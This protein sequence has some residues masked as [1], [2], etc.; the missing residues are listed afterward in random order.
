MCV[1]EFELSGIRCSAFK[2]KY[3]FEHVARH[4]EKLVAVI[5]E[6]LEYNA[7]TG[8]RHRRPDECMSTHGAP[9]KS[10]S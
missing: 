6:K 9:A 5:E 7:V 2:T 3:C 4:M 1:E 10:K 8:M